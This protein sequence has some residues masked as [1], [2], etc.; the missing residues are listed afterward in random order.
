MTNI[1]TFLQTVAVSE[2]GEATGQHSPPQSVTGCDLYGTHLTSSRDAT[3]EQRTSKIKCATETAK[4][5]GD[6]TVLWLWHLPERMLPELIRNSILELSATNTGVFVG[7]GTSVLSFGFH[8]WV[9]R[10]ETVL[11]VRNTQTCLLRED[12]GAS[13]LCKSQQQ[14]ISRQFFPQMKAWRPL[15]CSALPGPHGTHRHP[16]SPLPWCW[17]RRAAAC[18]GTFPPTPG[19]GLASEAAADRRRPGTT[20][21]HHSSARNGR[22][23]LSS[24]LSA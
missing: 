11:N 23:H 9:G 6:S 2:G 18:P 19:L 5:A 8:G 20:P 15:S 22:P 12:K 10:Q 4:K 17:F 24:R 14:H 7:D 1:V 21:R 3:I 13:H 16:A